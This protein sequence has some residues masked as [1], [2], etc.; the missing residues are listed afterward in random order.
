MFKTLESTLQSSCM[1]LVE[2]LPPVKGSVF[3]VHIRRSLVQNLMQYFTGR[4]INLLSI[5]TRCKAIKISWVPRKV[6]LQLLHA[7]L[8]W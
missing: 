3:E 8:Q 6:N 5:Y 1:D 2:P 4:N 7:C